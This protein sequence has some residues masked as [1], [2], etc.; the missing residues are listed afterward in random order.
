MGGERLE[1]GKPP[2]HSNI[3]E[4]VLELLPEAT[5]QSKLTD[6]AQPVQRVPWLD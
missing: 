3:E 6:G 5:V 4:V 1:V 2:R